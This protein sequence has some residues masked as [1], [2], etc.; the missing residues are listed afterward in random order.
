[1]T[2][3]VQTDFALVSVTVLDVNDNVPRFIYDNDLGLSL[4]FAGVSST[5]SAFTRVLS[6]KVEKF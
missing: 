3:G 5:A 6:V 4:Y 2:A 1:M